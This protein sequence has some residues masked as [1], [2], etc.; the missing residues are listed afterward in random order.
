MKLL[1]LT[2]AAFL[3]AGVVQAQD[4]AS[5]MGNPPMTPAPS[6]S[7]PT[8]NPA[9]STATDP[10]RSDAFS[11]SA[12][13]QKLAGAGY[14]TVRSLKRTSNGEWEA[15]LKKGSKEQRVTIAADGTVSPVVPM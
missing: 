2:S 14:G 3:A 10:T 9:P 6:A 12:A 5:Q 15:V 11:E 1:V 7:Q 13:R 4:T 8:R